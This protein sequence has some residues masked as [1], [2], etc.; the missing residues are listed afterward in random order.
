MNYTCL[1]S[2]VGV[3][4]RYGLDGPGI[5]FRWGRDFPHL[6]KPVLRSTDSIIVFVPGLFLGGRVAGA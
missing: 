1:Y 5:E 3:A 2:S 4:T 6:P